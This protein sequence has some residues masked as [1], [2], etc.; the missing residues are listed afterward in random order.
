MISRHLP[1]TP[2]ELENMLQEA[3]RE[4]F[5]RAVSFAE[6]RGLSDWTCKGAFES[7]QRYM[8]RSFPIRKKVPRRVKLGAG[9]YVRLNEAGEIVFCGEFGQMSVSTLLRKDLDI[10]AGL[11]NRPYEEVEE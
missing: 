6:A 9:L 10:I 1:Q 2:E 7:W 5:Q 4:G 11:L 3:R 8:R